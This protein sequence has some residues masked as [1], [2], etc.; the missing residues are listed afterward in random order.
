MMTQMTPK[1]RVLAAIRGKPYDQI[2]LASPV[3]IA[4]AECMDLAKAYF[5]YAN[6]NAT[7]MAS[8]AETGFQILKFDSVSPYFGTT[9]EVEALGC[10]VNWGNRYR[11]PR[12]L[13]SAFESVDAFKSPKD[14]LNCKSIH[15]AHYIC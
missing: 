8:L 12:V 1:E 15:N 14:Y 3:S 6:T 11:M 7:K 4:N 5:P 10:S 13:T 2:P 9:N